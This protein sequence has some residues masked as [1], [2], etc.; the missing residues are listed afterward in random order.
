MPKITKLDRVILVP[1]TNSLYIPGKL[2]DTENVIIDVG[3]GYYVQKVC[4]TS[5]ILKSLV[6]VLLTTYDPRAAKMQRSTTK[7]KSIMCEKTS[8][9]CKRRCNAS[10]I[11]CS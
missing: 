11:T 3:T 4:P 2:S 10:K 8:K 7:T 9:H 1:L 5:H 6:G